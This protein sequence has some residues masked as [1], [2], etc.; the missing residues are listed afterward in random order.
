MDG[1]RMHADGQEC[2]CFPGVRESGINV[3]Y[4]IF[5]GVALQSA[6]EP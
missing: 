5:G 1:A 2:R 6:L 4:Q 3:K